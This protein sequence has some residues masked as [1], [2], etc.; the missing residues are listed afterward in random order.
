MRG[1]K[2]NSGDTTTYHEKSLTLTSWATKKNARR[3]NQK[4]PI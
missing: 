1:N 3:N 4:R 2:L